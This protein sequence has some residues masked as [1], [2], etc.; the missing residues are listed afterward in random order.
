VGDARA[1]TS[2]VDGFEDRADEG[3]GFGQGDEVAEANVARSA[4]SVRQPLLEVGGQ[5]AVPTLHGRGVGYHSVEAHDLLLPNTV[6]TSRHHE[7]HI[8]R[9]VA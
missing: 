6:G 1:P 9:E 7:P 2:A 3:R 4:V 8:L 5:E